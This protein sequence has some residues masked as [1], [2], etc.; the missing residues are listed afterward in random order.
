M[1]LVIGPADNRT[2]RYV[3]QRANEKGL[4][5][6]AIDLEELCESGELNWQ[7]SPYEEPGLSLRD[8]SA[9]LNDFT[10]IYARLADPPTTF[11][12]ETERH[13]SVSMLT[14]LT[15]A[16]QATRTRVVNRPFHDAGN[17]SKPLQTEL[18]RRFGFRTPATLTT[19]NPAA[20]I[21]FA[22]ERDWRVVYK[23][24]GPAS[25]IVSRLTP[26]RTS[27]LER[28]R[29]CPLMLQ[30]QIEG[31]DIRAHIVGAEVFAEEIS[32]SGGV[33]ARH[34]PKADK[35]FRPARL[36]DGLHERC[37]AF[38]RKTGLVIA[39]FDFK[40][41]ADGTHFVLEA[42]PCPAFEGYDYRSKGKIS[43]ALL[44]I[45][46][47]SEAQSP[48]LPAMSLPMQAQETSQG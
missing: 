23:S 26:E 14:A 21:A 20:A 5:V 12:S 31:P 22:A 10:G 28:I 44:H 47:V 16:L 42:N 37:V 18:L 11:P 6:T 45:L 3:C 36:P 46:A 39:G 40:R 19:C 35:A 43:S 4:G 29:T 34:A 32:F 24:S 33:D 41:A 9:R 2:H 13:R 15:L 27:E 38:T 30:E 25:S 17:T 7:V 48:C 8:L 1:I